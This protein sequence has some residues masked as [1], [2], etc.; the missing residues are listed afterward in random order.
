MTLDE[1]FAFGIYTLITAIVGIPLGIA[2]AVILILVINRRSFG[3]SMDI[4]ID[5]FVL[6]QSLFLSIVAALLAGV[7]PAY[8]MAKIKPANA[9]REE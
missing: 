1:V 5:P 2:L 8:R 4:S 7:Y 9:L 6:S 3:W